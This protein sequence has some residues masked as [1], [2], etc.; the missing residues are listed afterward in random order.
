MFSFTVQ[1][2][3]IQEKISALDTAEARLMG[4]SSPL[5]RGSGYMTESLPFK[6]NYS[7]TSLFLVT[8]IEKSDN[9]RTHKMH[10]VSV[11][12]QVPKSK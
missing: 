4:F 5:I 12:E 9:C 3:T 1:V 2:S 10:D 11:Y 7:G 6:T 8:P